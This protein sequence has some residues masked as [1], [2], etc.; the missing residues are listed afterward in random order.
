MLDGKIGIYGFGKSTL[1]KKPTKH[2]MALPKTALL[3]LY[4]HTRFY[5]DRSAGDKSRGVW[6]SRRY[7]LVVSCPSYLRLRETGSNKVWGIDSN[8]ELYKEIL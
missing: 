7:E 5:L 1:V 2:S 3:M 4:D 6:L 8:G